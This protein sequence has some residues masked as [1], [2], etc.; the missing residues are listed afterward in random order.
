MAFDATPVLPDTIAP[1]LSHDQKIV[2]RAIEII[3]DPERWTQGRSAESADGVW[4]RVRS[5]HAVRF[6]AKGAIHL[7][8]HQLGYSRFRAAKIMLSFRKGMRRSLEHTNDGR[9]RLA[10]IA[11]MKAAYAV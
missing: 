10:A 7:A 9:G 5:K 1:V 6:C 2:L 4:V 8:A 3:S 11:R